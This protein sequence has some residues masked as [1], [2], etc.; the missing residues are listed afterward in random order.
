MA[1]LSELKTEV[2]K[3]TS[4][5][6]APVEIATMTPNE[7]EIDARKEVQGTDVINIDG[8]WLTSKMG[9]VIK[10]VLAWFHNWQS[11]A[12]A[13]EQ[14]LQTKKAE[15]DPAEV[16]AK[17]EQ[18]ESEKK[19]ALESITKRY[20]EQ[21]LGNAM[22]DFN[23]AEGIYEK[24]RKANNNKPPRKSPF[25]YWPA[26]VLVGAGEWLLNYDTFNIKFEIEAM[27]IGMTFLVAIAFALSS[28]F[29]GEFLK[30]REALMGIH[31]ETPRKTT[32]IIF[33]LFGTLL[34]LSALT[35]VILVRFYVI[36]DEMGAMSGPS[37]PGEEP[38]AQQSVLQLLLPTIFLNLLVYLIGVLI[39]YAVHDA[40]PGYQR[41]QKDLEDTREE[42]D[43]VKKKMDKE[44][45]Q[46][47]QD[48]L[49][50]HKEIASTYEDDGREAQECDELLKQ[51]ELKR[52]SHVKAVLKG[53]NDFIRSYKSV[54]VTVAVNSD[55][56]DDI[57]VGPDQLTVE[58]YRAKNIDLTEK[59]LYA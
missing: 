2:N 9:Q 35:A 31:V 59:D 58:Q 7:M 14:K 42:L 24:M 54:L 8:L 32:Y 57:K 46:V 51:I 29:H 25:W 22:R 13:L 21:E 53:I 19:A 39:S 1:S 16:R 52:K 23:V 55:N 5:R 41:A 40:V 6:E 56:G 49:K 28:H 17:K 45:T 11:R 34:L 12:E 3:L 18:V 20:E 4:D 37:L 36:Q 43:R 30:Q 26:L 48:A 27:A 47:E 15:Y 33:Q 44:I 10:P 50:K 38:I